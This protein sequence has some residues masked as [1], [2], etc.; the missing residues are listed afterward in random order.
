MSMAS[1]FEG[2]FSAYR[3]VRSGLSPFDGDG[4]FRW[5]GRWTSPGR[6]VIH[7]AESYALAVLESLVHF[8]IGEL[9]PR[10]VVV[11]LKIRASI[12]RQ[13]LTADAL[14]GWDAPAPN[15]VSR[16]FGDRWYDD[17]RSAVLIVP[18]VL[19]P[20]ECNVLIHQKHPASRA[21]DVGEP[22]PA[23]LDDRLRALVRDTGG[24]KS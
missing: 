12:S 13:V 20:F 10:L 16:G 6:H 8:S 22:L 24:R 1:R 11:Q 5:G 19:S 21:I 2:A 7:A 4:A 14:P 3:I 17:E 15:S 9:P 23:T 18:S